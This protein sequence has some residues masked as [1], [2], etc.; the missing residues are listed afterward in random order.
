LFLFLDYS[1]DKAVTVIFK[2][3]YFDIFQLIEF[4]MI[5]TFIG[6]FFNEEKS[7]VQ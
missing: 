2:I 7:L 5:F 3:I 4:L 6:V 1:R